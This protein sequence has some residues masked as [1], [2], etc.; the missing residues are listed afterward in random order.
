MDITDNNSVPMRSPLPQG[1]TVLP[2]MWGEASPTEPTAADERLDSSSTVKR[3]SARRLAY[4]S[5]VREAKI[6]E[7][8][9]AIKHGTYHVAAEQIA[10]KMLRQTL[11]HHLP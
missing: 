11:R 1:E 4:A 2:H 10:D 6:R 5:E 7:L 8:Q 9:D 3:Q